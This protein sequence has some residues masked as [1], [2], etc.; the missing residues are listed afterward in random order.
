MYVKKGY[1]HRDSIIRHEKIHA[2]QL[3]ELWV[4]PHYMLY[5][6]FYMI[7]IFKYKF[8]H[9]DA[10]RHIPFEQEAYT[11]DHIVDYLENRKKFAWIKF[12]KGEYGRK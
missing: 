10:Y 1:E 5:G 3:K 6:I 8:C 7:N 2:L 12:M 9:R 4:L 11:N